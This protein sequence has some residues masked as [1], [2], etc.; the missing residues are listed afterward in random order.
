MLTQIKG[1]QVKWLAPPPEKPLERSRCSG[2]V[3]GWS[4]FTTTIIASLKLI[5]GVLDKNTV[6]QQTEGTLFHIIN[7]EKGPYKCMETIFALQQCISNFQLYKGFTVSIR[8]INIS[9]S[10]TEKIIDE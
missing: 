6:G 2:R 8:D 3:E 10:T 5:S 4:K 9:D 7:N 1:T